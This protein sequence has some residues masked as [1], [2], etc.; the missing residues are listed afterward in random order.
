[1]LPGGDGAGVHVSAD[2][3]DDERTGA[4]KYLATVRVEED[5][6]VAAAAKSGL[7]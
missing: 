6:T 2:R 7:A 4:A 3:I 1:L 5:Q